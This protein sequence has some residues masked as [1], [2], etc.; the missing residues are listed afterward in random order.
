VTGHP[1]RVTLTT[2]RLP[3][4]L[5]ATLVMPLLA[6]GSS[7]GQPGGSLILEFARAKDPGVVTLIRHAP[8]PGTGDPPGFKLGD[9]STQRNLSDRG[10]S[11]AARLG[12]ALGIVGVTDADV[13]SSQWCR[14]L[15]TARLLDVGPVIEDPWLNSFFADR[16]DE[17]AATE[18]L[19]LA[20]VRKVD[21]TRPT[22]FVTHQVNI[23]ALTGIVPEEAE[24]VFVRA[25]AE[26]T[27]EVVGRAHVP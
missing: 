8:A 13:Y 18:A 14:C 1:I 21:S 16:G 26:G 3:G 7:A 11:E 4:L 15:E 22:F 12:D 23:T 9:C 20:V 10:R 24:A 17:G 6:L 2:M 27:I 25:T 5:V 19:R